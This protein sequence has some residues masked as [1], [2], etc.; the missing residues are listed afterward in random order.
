[1][2]ACQPRWGK[3][4][5]KVG[6]ITQRW[7]SLDSE[8]VLLSLAGSPNALQVPAKNKV[9]LALPYHSHQTKFLPRRLVFHCLCLNDSAGWEPGKRS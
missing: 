6:E 2:A 1:M 9:V 7:S 8:A 4:R 3:A 5:K